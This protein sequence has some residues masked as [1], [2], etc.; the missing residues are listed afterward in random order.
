MPTNRIYTFFIGLALLFWNPLAYYLL[1]KNTPSFDIRW[2]LIFY[3]II[4]LIGLGILYLFHR[5]RIHPKLKNPILSI[6]VLGILFAFMAL[7]NSIIGKKELNEKEGLIFIPGTEVR[8]TSTEFDYRV[9]INSLGLRDNEFN[10]RKGDKFRIICVG[11]SWTIGW[12]VNLED[13]YPK[14]L[15]R[16]LKAKGK[17]IEV[18]NCGQAGNYT[19]IY[20]RQLKKLIPALQ[21][22]LVLVGVLQGDDLAQLYETDSSFSPATKKKQNALHKVLADIRT[23]LKSSFGNISALFKPKKPIA[24]QYNWQQSATSVIN[25]FTPQQKIRFNLL[26]DTVQKLFRTGNLNPSLMNFYLNF[27]DRMI[28]FNDP[29]HPATRLAI[30][31]MDKDLKDMKSTCLNQHIPLVFVNMPMSLFTG[32]QVIRTPTDIL[33]PYFVSNNK[34]D[35]IYR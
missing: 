32:H 18:I 24:V 26:E 2:I 35:S 28:V 25:G 5:N 8:Y 12:G 9:S 16:Y 7:V 22:D 21:P 33:D 3:S 6:S 14:Q 31:R 27:P 17:N 1:Y 10:P 23:H 29:A 15:E 34:I 13:T 11:D 30:S 4:F 19:T 20:A